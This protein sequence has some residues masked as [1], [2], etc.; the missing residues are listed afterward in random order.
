MRSGATAAATTNKDA[1]VA[2]LPGNDPAAT[3]NSL[4]N[5]TSSSSSSANAVG[6]DPPAYSSSSNSSYYAAP[7]ETEPLTG[8][9]STS[10][11]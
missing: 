5:G 11:V 3:L 4:P 6:M 1:A 7:S 8:N 2:D 10:M 9:G